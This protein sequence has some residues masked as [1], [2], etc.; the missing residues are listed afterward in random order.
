VLPVTTR[1]DR[2][3]TRF[4]S[5]AR[6]LVA[7]TWARGLDP[8]RVGETASFYCFSGEIP[9]VLTGPTGRESNGGDTDGTTSREHG[10]ASGETGRSS[11]GT[12][13]RSTRLVLVWGILAGLSGVLGRA[14]LGP[15]QFMLASDVYYYA[16]ES[17]LAG[18]DIYEVA[19]P[20][21]PGYHYIYPPIVILVFVPHVLTGSPAGAFALQTLLNVCFAA[22]IAVVLR[23]AL[24][25]RGVVLA[26]LD[27]LLL[28]AFALVST[29]SAISLI[30]GQVNIGLGFAV[31]VGLDALDRNRDD[32]AGLAFGAAALV[33]VFPAALGLWL[34]RRRAARGVVLA[35][36]VGVTGL[37]AGLV[38]LGPDVTGTYLS[39]VLTGRYDGFD[40]A[41][42]PTQT[43]GGAQ[44][45]VAALA[46]LGPPYVTPVA[47]L[48]VTPVLCYL[49]LDIETDRQ[50]QATVLGTILVTLLFLP[51][52]RLYMV[53]FV[54]PLVVLL[55]T[56]PPGRSRL[57]L[58]GGTVVS[59]VRVEFEIVERALS[60]LPLGGLEATVLAVVERLFEVVLPPTVGLWLLLAACVLVHY[61]A[62]G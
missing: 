19:P 17:L 7:A 20:D 61:D 60:T 29:H 42:D 5:P 46:G 32:I 55:Y 45:Q 10:V 54:F 49:Y 52:Q 56:L 24:H 38:A 22:G 39:D 50:R 26:R 4:D 59:F 36:A 14:V 30:N 11:P 2:V 25:R 18:G 44:R 34:L 9:S 43:R 1:D 37:L 27:S 58:L 48:A 33:K 8:E 35:T 57:L 3:V 12:P 23:R 28:F 62:R 53:L 40:G 21:R 41:P 47:A 16:A 31:A 6:R 51:L 13:A 15:E